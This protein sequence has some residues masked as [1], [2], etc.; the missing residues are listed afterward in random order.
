MTTPLKADIESSIRRLE[1]ALM[2]GRRLRNGR[3]AYAMLQ[4]VL[5]TLRASHPALYSDVTSR[6]VSTFDS[7]LDSIPDRVIVEMADGADANMA[8]FTSATGTGGL[9]N[10]GVAL[11]EGQQFQ[12]RNVADFADGAL[13]TAKGSALAVGDLFT[14]DATPFYAGNATL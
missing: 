8:A 10:A 7:I 4:K 12:L 6:P 13:A 9:H 3:Y 1:D 14:A 5:V 11:Y 2:H